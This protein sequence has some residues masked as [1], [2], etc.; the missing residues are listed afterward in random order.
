MSAMVRR[1]SVGRA[2]ATLHDAT[3]ATSLVSRTRE[4]RER[5]R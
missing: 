3:T 4:A 2:F 1:E 5:V